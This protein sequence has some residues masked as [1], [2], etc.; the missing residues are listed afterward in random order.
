MLYSQHQ[1]KSAQSD[2][3]SKAWD[4]ACDSDIRYFDVH[5]NLVCISRGKFMKVAQGEIG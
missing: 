1:M 3:L 2:V 5:R 4:A